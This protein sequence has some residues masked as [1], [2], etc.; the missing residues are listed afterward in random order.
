MLAI[1]ENVTVLQTLSGDPAELFEYKQLLQGRPFIA[2][3][4]AYT[5]DFNTSEIHYWCRQKDRD[6]VKFCGFPD[7]SWRFLGRMSGNY[8]D[9]GTLWGLRETLADSENLKAACH[10][11]GAIGRQVL[12]ILS[13]PL[14]FS[15]V[16]YKLLRDIHLMESNYGLP[17]VLGMLTLISSL[18]KYD[19]YNSP[20]P[21]FN[22]LH[23]LEESFRDI[24]SYDIS[25]RFAAIRS[26]RLPMPPFPAAKNIL[27]LKN[28][29]LLIHEAVV[30]GSTCAADK[31][32]CRRIANGK[33]YLY[34]VLWPERATL[35]IEYN[36]ACD[37]W[38][39][40]ECL[41]IYNQEVG[42]HCR[43]IVLQWLKANQGTA[44]TL[45]SKNQQLL[46]F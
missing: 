42:P 24:E 16:S 19:E 45:K 35:E 5:V 30:Q 22:T 14:L 41:G 15:M 3:T 34:R 8:F 9:L 43:A 32:Y 23:Q 26:F 4:L 44:R 46:L 18:V 17:D 39:L 13:D 20:L 33:A 29:S 36:A 12:A 28:P 25:S 37:E 38:M 27:P 2:W 11:Q 7:R 6:I 21:T 10:L 40:S 31:S 1:E